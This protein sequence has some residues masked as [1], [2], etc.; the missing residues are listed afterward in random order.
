MK[1]CVTYGLPCISNI[2]D[3]IKIC[4]NASNEGLS[5]YFS[6]NSLTLGKSKILKKKRI[7]AEGLRHQK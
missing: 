1:M 4:N 6:K 7:V 2:S 5:H 3:V